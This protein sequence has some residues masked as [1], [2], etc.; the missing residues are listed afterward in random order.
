MRGIVPSLACC[1]LSQRLRK[2]LA[3]PLTCGAIDVGASASAGPISIRTVEIDGAPWFVAVDVCKCLGFPRHTSGK[4]NPSRYT[5]H[6]EDDQKGIERLDT[7]RGKQSC[8]VVSEAG[9]YR[10]VMRSDKPEAHKFQDWVTRDVL[11]AIR[12]GG[13][14]IMGEEGRRM[15]ALR[16]SL[17]RPRHRPPPM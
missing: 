15:D 14:Y 1:C 10:M 3:P 4:V 2:L 8:L 9:L 11:P 6:L 17:Q 16:D 13:G 7:V 12:K 5:S